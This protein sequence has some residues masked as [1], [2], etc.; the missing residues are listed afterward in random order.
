[1]LPLQMRA[2]I[3]LRLG[4]H[5]AAR[6]DCV[7]GLDLA[8]QNFDA[9]DPHVAR[10]RLSCSR[11]LLS[12]G[13]WKAT[14]E[15]AELDPAALE[16]RPDLAFRNAYQRAELALL[17]GD[18]AAANDH[19]AATQAVWDSARDALKKEAASFIALEWLIN[20]ASGKRTAPAVDFGPCLK[21]PVVCAAQAA[22]LHA[23]GADDAAFATF[24]EANAPGC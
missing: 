13:D 7:R 14:A 12:V 22:A 11:T 15:F 24:A 1:M 20:H 17:S 9:S 18:L 6:D 21:E 19:L 2:L 8:R 4:R 5:A 3:K 10:F 16:G 23:N